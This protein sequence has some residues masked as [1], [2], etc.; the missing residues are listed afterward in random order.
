MN[1]QETLT[2][3]IEYLFDLPSDEDQDWTEEDH[4]YDTSKLTV[5]IR[6]RYS[7]TGVSRSTWQAAHIM[8]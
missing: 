3:Y 6:T 4:Y 5:R 7:A 2:Q 8:G 1:T